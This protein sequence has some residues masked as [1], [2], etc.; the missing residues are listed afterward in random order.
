MKKIL[1]ICI[2]AT[3]LLSCIASANDSLGAVSAESS[4]EAFPSGIN[5]YIGEISDEDRKA[6]EIRFEDLNTL[7]AKF[8]D[9]LHGRISDSEY[10]AALTAWLIKR[11]GDLAN[12][13]RM[14][15]TPSE[16]SALLSSNAN[17]SKAIGDNK[18]VTLNY[19]ASNND[20]KQINSYYCGPATAVFMLRVRQ[21]WYDANNNWISQTTLAN[22]MGTNSSVGTYLGQMAPAL[23][24][25]S[26]ISGNSYTY[27]T[28]YPSSSSTWTLNSSNA[29][30]AT[31]D[32][33]YAAGLDCMM[34]GTGDSTIS[35]TYYLPSW[36]NHLKTLGSGVPA[37]HYVPAY[38]FD[39]TNTNSRKLTIF[40]VYDGFG[41]WGPQTIT[42]QL[43]GNLTYPLG[44]IVK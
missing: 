32:S 39:A 8:D 24:S 36:E 1:S 27:T 25:Y 23:N 19:N 16:K 14:M 30:I 34:Y 18:K 41:S 44:V 21:I 31:I 11:G 33:G 6:E 10:E 29:V 38:G 22:K 37:G 12:V 26:G 40:E 35:P 42:C 7:N 5:I 2:V 43:M 9:Y 4:S 13:S 15:L 3:L 28:M 20:L 17:G